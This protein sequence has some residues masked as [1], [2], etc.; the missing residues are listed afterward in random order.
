MAEIQ[1]KIA[2]IL[3]RARLWS[4]AQC[5]SLFVFSDDEI[6]FSAST[7]NKISI[8][9]V[10]LKFLRF[11]KLISIQSA[12]G[13]P[14]TTGIPAK[15]FPWTWMTSWCSRNFENRRYARCWNVTIFNIRMPWNSTNICRN[16]A[17]IDTSRASRDSHSWPS[18]SILRK[19]TCLVK[20]FLK[21]TVCTSI[22]FSFSFDY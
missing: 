11:A 5:A 12:I 6:I 15:L 4:R 16:C 1:A 21:E 10:K 8:E 18:I 2:L 9:D 20:Y 13:I 3:E 17:K 22:I 14:S 19:S 7:H